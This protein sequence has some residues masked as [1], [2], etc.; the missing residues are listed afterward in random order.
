VAMA[1]GHSLAVHSSSYRWASQATT[2]AAFEAV[3]SR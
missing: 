2:A 3:F 1:M